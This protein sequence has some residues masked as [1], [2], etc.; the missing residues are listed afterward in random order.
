MLYYPRGDIVAGNTEYKNTWQKENKDR[1]LLILP[2]GD[3]DKIKARAESKG[4]SL[5][6]Y[7]NK[8]IDADMEKPGE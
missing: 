6:A 1:I 7:I 4:M 3:K 8:L 2:K 5:N